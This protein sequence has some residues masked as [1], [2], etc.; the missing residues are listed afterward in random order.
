GLQRRDYVYIDDV[1]TAFVAAMAP[2]S[3]ADA[4]P[5]TVVV[6]SGTAVNVLQLREL[7]SA[8]TG[9]EIP[10]EHADQPP[11]EMRAVVVD[12]RRANALGLGPPTE[13]ADGLR[14]TWE[15]WPAG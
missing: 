13:L 9:G 10:V 8:A 15:A 4:W 1:V 11:G 6:G 12:R 3:A 5:G 14:R 7:V 2:S